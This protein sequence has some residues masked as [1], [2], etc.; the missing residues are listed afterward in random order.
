M[1]ITLLLLSEKKNLQKKRSHHYDFPQTWSA[2]DCSDKPRILRTKKNYFPQTWSAL[3]CSDEPSG[4]VA[5]FCLQVK[6]DEIKQDFSTIFRAAQ[7]LGDLKRAEGGFEDA[8]AGL[9]AVAACKG[10][11]ITE[12][13][14]QGQAPGSNE[15]AGNGGT[16]LG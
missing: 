6:T 12:L 2:L 10:D 4:V 14:R 8:Q 1:T 5:Q 15:G 3:D 16:L 13:E 7:K 11:E 9:I